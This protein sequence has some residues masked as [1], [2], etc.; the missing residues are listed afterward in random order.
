ML[1]SISSW[2]DEID[3]VPMVGWFI[4]WLCSSF[5][6]LKSAPCSGHS[7]MRIMEGYM[8]SYLSYSSHR[9]V[10]S[11]ML[12]PHYPEV[13]SF[14]APQSSIPETFSPTF[15][16][17]PSFRLHK[18]TDVLYNSCT[19]HL[20]ERAEENIGMLECLFL[21]LGR[22]ITIRTFVSCPHACSW[23]IGCY[24]LPAYTTS[25]TEVR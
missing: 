3:S 7:C 18:P 20:H 2:L 16:P 4:N 9:W 25:T 17:D 11:L 21:V 22:P 8:H 6:F 14:H 19:T 10:L 15:L 12:W 5:V 1:V 23:L 13:V 24:T